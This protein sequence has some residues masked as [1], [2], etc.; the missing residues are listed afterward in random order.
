MYH[1]AISRLLL[2]AAGSILPYRA[3]HHTEIGQLLRVSHRPRLFRSGAVTSDAKISDISTLSFLPEFQL[4]TSSGSSD[5]CGIR[6]VLPSLA[7]LTSFAPGTI[8]TWKSPW[9]SVYA[10]WLSLEVC[11][12]PGTFSEA[13]SLCCSCRS[14]DAIVEVIVNNADRMSVFFIS[15]DERPWRCFWQGL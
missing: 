4:R 5:G 1:H 11:N 2:Y 9:P 12:I 14:S 8:V 7:I 6:T 10:S 13:V 3:P 15:V